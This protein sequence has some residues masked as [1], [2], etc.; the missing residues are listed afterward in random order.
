ML[1]KS[2][3]SKTL[4]VGKNCFNKILALFSVSQSMD[5]LNQ[6]QIYIKAFASSKILIA[7]Y[8]QEF[9]CFDLYYHYYISM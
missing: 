4:P 3:L 1:A 9:I 5:K 7:T 2:N 6:C 8:W